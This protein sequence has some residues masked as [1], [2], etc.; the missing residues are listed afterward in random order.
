MSKINFSGLNTV[1]KKHDASGE[2]EKF[3]DWSIA[4]GGYDL[5]WEI[6]YQDYTVLQCVD[7]ELQGG[8]RPIPEFD[9]EE[10]QKLIEKVKGIYI[11]LK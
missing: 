2:Y 4:K 8:F 5:W 11:D 1:L 6:Y 7:G 9:L 10:E 3:L